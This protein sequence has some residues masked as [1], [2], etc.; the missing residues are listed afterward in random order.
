MKYSLMKF[1]VVL[2]FLPLLTHRGMISDGVRHNFIR[3]GVVVVPGQNVS[4]DRALELAIEAGAEDVQES[5][6][7]EEQPI[8]KVRHVSKES[9]P[10]I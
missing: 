5:E 8:L 9:S 4:T 7:E 10:E 2:C 3:K 1:N 6:D